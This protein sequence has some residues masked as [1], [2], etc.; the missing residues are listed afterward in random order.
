MVTRLFTWFANAYKVIK[1]VIVH[2]FKSIQMITWFKRTVIYFIF[3]PVSHKIIV[4]L[5]LKTADFV[6]TRAIV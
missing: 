4:A 1:S 5:T 2:T 6:Y 3:A